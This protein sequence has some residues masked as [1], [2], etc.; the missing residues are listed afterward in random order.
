M[1][2]DLDLGRH[3]PAVAIGQRY[4]AFARTSEVRQHRAI[5]TA[6]LAQ[7]LYFLDESLCARAVNSGFRLIAFVQPREIILQPRVDRQQFASEQVEPLAQQRELAKQRFED[8]ALVGAE[9]RDGFEIGLQR[10]QQPDDL[11]VTMTLRLQPTPR[12][13]AVE[14][15]ADVQLEQIARRI[16]GSARRFQLN[17]SEA[18]RREIEPIDEGV[19][20]PN[21]IVRADL[22]VDR[23]R[24]RQKLV[25]FEAGNVRYAG[26]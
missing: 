24:Q 13:H 16:A 4:L 20:E 15:A 2:R 25:A 22:I 23:L 7:S 1:V 19:D 8:G 3:G 17:R 6:L 11:D 21:G 18:C 12:P 5:L 26:S 10:P 14:I 9:I